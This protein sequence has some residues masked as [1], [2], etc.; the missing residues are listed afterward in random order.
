MRLTEILQPDCLKVPLTAT[1]KREAVYELADLLVTR[2][3]IR[4][5]EGFK[6]AVWKREGIR[7]TGIGH[8]IAIPHGKTPGVDRVRLAVGRTAEPL[9]FGA[10]D[11]KPVRLIFLLASP[12]DHNGPHI[13]ALGRISRML[14][15]ETLRERMIEAGTAEELMALIECYERETGA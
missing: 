13:Q 6:E 7:T 14:F 12:D 3:A 9:E 11:K 4:D 10:I 8:G 5:P 15:D 1:D 2:T